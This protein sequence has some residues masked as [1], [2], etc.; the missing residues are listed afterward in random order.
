MRAKTNEPGLYARY[1]FYA[2]GRVP[3]GH[4]EWAE[5]RLD[6]RLRWILVHFVLE[7]LGTA[8]LF[9]AL[10]ALFGEFALGPVVLTVSALNVLLAPLS[11]RSARARARQELEPPA[12]VVLAQIGEPVR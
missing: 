4:A 8:V 5:R 7:V 3:R 6:G 10:V 9:A 2:G 11:A 12:A 1:R